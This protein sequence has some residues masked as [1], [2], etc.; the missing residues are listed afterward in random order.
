MR[1]RAAALCGL[2]ACA[3]GASP[4][5]A[6][7]TDWRSFDW[8]PI[9]ALPAVE[10]PPE[11]F[12]RWVDGA[13]VPVDRWAADRRP[14]LLALFQRYMYGWSPEALP[15][16]AVALLDAQPIAMGTLTQWEAWTGD[17]RF[18]VALYL[19]AGPGP[20]PVFLG[21]NKCGNRTVRA[22]DAL[23]HG[24]GW[25]E[26]GCDPEPGSRADLWDID[27]ALAAGVGVATVHQSDFHPDDPELTGGMLGWS[28][29]TA[30]GGDGWGAVG[31]WAYGL[32]RAADVLLLQPEVGDV[33]VFG[34][35]RRGKAA[36]WAAANDERLAGVWAH[37]SGTAGSA[38]V[39]TFAG[40]SV[41]AI[42]TLFPHW[43]NDV[44]PEFAG[45]ELQLP[46]DQHRLVALAAPRWVRLTDGDDD[47]WAN[48]AG[49]ALAAELARPVFDAVGG[50]VVW[51]QRPGGHSVNAEDWRGALAAWAAY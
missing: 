23:V 1:T 25:Q 9:D 35:S 17:R 7:T 4:S 30:S 21:L 31:A 16:E 34:H 10:E 14:E 50:A 12:V 48:P 22:D 20:H 28:A 33:V 11:P 49:S 37:Q 45:R 8:P 47:A 2:V 38:V 43:F 5:G 39:R 42:N 44:Y 3:E 32:S 18:V 13:A 36:L 27:A 29:P 15:A 19:P 6:S 26:P 46:V 24:G 41:L 40:E 51:E